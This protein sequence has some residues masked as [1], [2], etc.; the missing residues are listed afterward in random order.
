MAIN[1]MATTGRFPELTQ[2]LSGKK[3]FTPATRMQVKPFGNPVQMDRGFGSPMPMPKAP[4]PPAQDPN[5]QKPM[6]SPDFSRPIGQE[7]GFTFGV[8]GPVPPRFFGAGGFD[9]HA[10]GRQEFA[11]RMAP[12]PEPMMPEAPPVAPPPQRVVPQGEPRISPEARPMRA[13]PL[14]EAPVSSPVEE[15]PMV[16]TRM[17]DRRKK[18]QGTIN[19]M[20]AQGR[21]GREIELMREKLDAQRAKIQKARR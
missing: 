21:G 12:P 16:D 1:R 11:Q 20:E 4:V 7:A 9:A 2:A 13:P 17:D 18:I 5:F 15:M 8:N 3:G 6:S 10:Q 19:K 14:K